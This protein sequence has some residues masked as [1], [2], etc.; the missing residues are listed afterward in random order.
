MHLLPLCGKIPLMSY[1]QA[2]E[3]AWKDIAALTDEKSFSVSFLSDAYTVDLASKRIAST[4]DNITAKDYVAILLLHY[5]IKKLTLGELP[6]RSG[7]WISFNELE[8]GEGYYPTFKK[9]TIDQ[10]LRKYGSRP[11]ALLT[12]QRSIKVMKAGQG[13]VSIEIHPFDEITILIKMSKAD[14]EFGPDAN[15]LFDKNI[16]QIFCM[17]DAVVITELLIHKL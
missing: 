16:S 9:R 6:G 15:I 8:G 17:E 4:P 2:L 13:D 3:K 5:L 7:E 12:T 14:E 11:E 1:A 10:V